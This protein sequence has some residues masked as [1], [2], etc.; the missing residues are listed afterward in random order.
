[1]SIDQFLEVL[2][3]LLKAL[4]DLPKEVANKA[5]YIHFG[6]EAAVMWVPKVC[7]GQESNPGHLESSDSLQK[8]PKNVASKPKCLN[9]F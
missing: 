2:F 9:F 6:P 1:M 8:L 4:L 5:L 7:T 3:C